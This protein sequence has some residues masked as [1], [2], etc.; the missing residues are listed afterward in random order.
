MAMVETTENEFIKMSQVLTYL[1]GQRSSHTLPGRF[2]LLIL[3][4]S[5]E[6]DVML[7]TMLGRVHSRYP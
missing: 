1:V 4:L 7:S 3:V 6:V 5:A 2:V